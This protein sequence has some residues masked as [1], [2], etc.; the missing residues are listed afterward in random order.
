[1]EKAKPQFLKIGKDGLELECFRFVARALSKDKTE[2][3]SHI[4]FLFITDDKRVLATDGKRL[5]TFVTAYEIESGF[6]EVVK[7][8]KTSF[9]MIK[10]DSVA[11]YPDFEEVLDDTAHKTLMTGADDIGVFATFAKIVR[12]LPE[13]ETISLDFIRD[14]LNFGSSFSMKWEVMIKNA[15]SGIIFKNDSCMAVVMALRT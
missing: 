10:S 4:K 1:M 11:E 5:H 2:R 14:V 13:T 3:R 12:A 9:I 15:E 8:M 7:N 6:Y